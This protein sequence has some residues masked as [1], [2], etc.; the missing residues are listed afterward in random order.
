MVGRED[1]LPLFEELGKK[2]MTL[3]TEV[4]GM[5]SETKAHEMRAFQAGEKGDGGNKSVYSGLLPISWSSDNGNQG[6]I[7]SEGANS[8]VLSPIGTYL[9]Q[10]AANSAGVL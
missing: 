1:V 6:F 3:P 8:V 4:F 7:R 2:A 9:A 10:V 5:A